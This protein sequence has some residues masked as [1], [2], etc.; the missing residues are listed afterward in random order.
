M[1][2]FNFLLELFD[3][4]KV[5]I[6]VNFGWRLLPG[7]FREAI[8]RFEA[9]EEDSSW[10]LL[11][12]AMHTDNSVHRAELFEQALEEIS[13]AE[14]FRSFFLA[15]TGERI[16][17]LQEEKR[18]L[19]QKNETW[20]LFAFCLIGENDAAVRFEKIAANQYSPGLDRLLKRI[21]ADEKGHQKKAELLLSGAGLAPDTVHR[22]TRRIR[23]VR[24]RDAWLR[25]GR[26]IADLVSSVLLAFVYFVFSGPFALVARRRL[27]EAPRVQR[28]L[29]PHLP[30]H[31]P[32]H[33]PTEFANERARPL[34]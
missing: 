22:E 3:T 19:F 25:S 15:H 30:P 20:K 13:H 2:V 7:K 34:V 12:G 24:F 11:R 33:L 27:T 6:L 28:H 5:S 1:R 17:R 21:L 31:L 16:R 14:E 10:H 9:T 26:Q 18:V 8:R 32:G 23:L 29:A 4:I